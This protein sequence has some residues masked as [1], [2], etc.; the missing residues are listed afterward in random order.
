[1]KQKISEQTIG[2]LPQTEVQAVKKK[3][4]ELRVGIPRELGEGENRVVLTPEAIRLL[5][6]NGIQVC[7][8]TD[9]GKSAHFSDRAYSEAGAKVVYSAKEA[10]EQEIVLK[11]DPPTAEEIEHMKPGSTLISALQVGKQE[12][13]YF[14]ALNQKRITGLSFEHLEDKVGGMPV[15][16]AMSEIAGS[17]VMQIAAHYLS[18]AHKGKG[19]LLGGITG[20]PPTEVVIIGAGTVAEYAARTGLGLGASI[21]IFDNQ[22]YK[23][24]R[25]K[26]LLGQQVYTSTIDS[27]GLAQALREADVVIGALRAEKGRNKLVV[28]EEM[29]AEMRPGSVIIDVS[30]DQGGCI[31]TSEL[32][33]HLNPTFEKYEVLHYGVPNIPSRVPQTASIALSNI[34]TPILL[35][36]QDL[37]GAEEMIFNYRWFLKGIYTYR[38]SLTNA[39]LGRV[40][41]LPHK[42]LQ[43][44]LAAR[45]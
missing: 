44:L 39:Y 1:M 20:V 27:V 15:V 36:M 42:E 11:V 23:L 37:G 19:V 9:A 6:F 34:F 31:E 21:K 18:S 25:I 45:Y 3:G 33:T 16:R 17:S 41:G 13:G 30:I 12:S 40:F 29:V 7:V 10:L 32:T 35:Q 38:G 8:E 43:L 28:T 24:R 2:I 26:Q 14:H 22:L 5:S 4:K